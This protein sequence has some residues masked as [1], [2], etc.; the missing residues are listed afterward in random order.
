MEPVNSPVADD[1]S[2]T[3]TGNVAPEGARLAGATWD[4]V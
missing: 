4:T 3:T 2:A 1:G